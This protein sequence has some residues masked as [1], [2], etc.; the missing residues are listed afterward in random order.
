MTL[1]RKT[2]DFI[3]G[4]GHVRQALSLTR[5]ECLHPIEVGLSDAAITYGV[6]HST[7]D[8]QGLAHWRCSGPHR[9]FPFLYSANPSGVPALVLFSVGGIAGNTGKL[10]FLIWALSMVMGFVHRT[11]V[12]ANQ[13]HQTERGAI[14][15]EYRTHAAAPY[16]DAPPDFAVAQWLALH[17]AELQMSD[18][19]KTAAAIAALTAGI[20]TWTLFQT[21]SDICSSAPCRASHWA[22]AGEAASTGGK[23]A[24]SM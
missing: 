16:T 10:A 12:H 5:A 17:G 9:P 19:D 1:R 21:A 22:T 24:F 18:A 3:F 15:L 14:S 13:L 6:C 11:G 23:S 2:T 4:R 20:R 8:R 7:V